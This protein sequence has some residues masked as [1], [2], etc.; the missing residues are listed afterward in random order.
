MSATAAEQFPPPCPKCGGKMWDNRET[1]R[2]VKAPDAKCR[3]KSCD[4][5]IWPPRDAGRAPARP[6]APAKAPVSHG[7]PLPYEEEEAAE[8]KRVTT[9]DPFDAIASRHAKC[10]RHVVEHEVPYLEKQGVT[11]DAAAVSALVAQLFIETSRR[12][13]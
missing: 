9:V 7:G 3:D 10:L 11:T 6:A 2:N 1:K 12:A 5:V 8:L 13:A 4:G